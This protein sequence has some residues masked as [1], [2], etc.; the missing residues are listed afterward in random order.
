LTSSLSIVF[1]GTPQFAADHLSHLI[2]MGYQIEAVITQPDKPGKRG[3]K[4]VPSEVKTVALNH[5]L[6]VLQPE[7]LKAEHLENL[8]M[9][10]MVVVAYG[11]I[12]REPVLALPKFGCINVHG[13]LLPRWRGAAPIQRALEAGDTESGV[14]IMQMEKGLDTG[15]VLMS[16]VVAIDPEDTAGSLTSKIASA[17]QTALAQVLDRLPAALDEIKEQPLEGVTYAHKID[18]AEGRINWQDSATSISNK[19]RAFNPDPVAFSDLSDLRV[20]FWRTKTEIGGSDRTPGEIIRLDKT[21]LY[22]VTGD[23]ILIVTLLQLPL[24]KGSL[25]TP[26]D[27]MNARR[28][29]FTPGKCF[30]G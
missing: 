14:C 3:K 25:L 11:Q 4:P 18:K 2:A 28:E 6:P 27:L 22:I 10:V 26:Q 12:L 21:G 8:S 9:D 23:G 24:G 5:G 20:K 13:S 1:A 15:P 30:S 17:G 19:V 7:R 29:L 16:V